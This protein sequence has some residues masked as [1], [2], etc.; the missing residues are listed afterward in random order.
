MAAASP[1]EETGHSKESPPGDEESVGT[2][3]RTCAAAE[4]RAPRDEDNR[5]GRQADVSRS[6]MDAWGDD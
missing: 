6:P 2:A 5:G 1:D 4:V 3:K